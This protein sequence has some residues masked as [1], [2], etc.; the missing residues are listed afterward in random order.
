M[1]TFWGRLKAETRQRQTALLSFCDPDKKIHLV[2]VMEE[3]KTLASLYIF[4]PFLDTNAV[5]LMPHIEAY[6]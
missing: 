3:V 1:Q 5:T 4:F 6:P 2:R